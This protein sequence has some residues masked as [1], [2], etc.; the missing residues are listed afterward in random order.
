MRKE[1]KVNFNYKKFK[2]NVKRG[3]PVRVWMMIS[4]TH[5]GSTY[6]LLPPNF[7]WFDGKS[8]VQVPQSRGQV[9]MW[10][11][12]QDILN[13]VREYNPDTILNGSDIIDG[14]NAKTPGVHR[15]IT[16]LDG[17]LDAAKEVFEYLKSDSNDNLRKLESVSGSHYHG[18]KDM[19]V[20]KA[21]TD[22]WVAGGNPGCYHGS[23]ANLVVSGTKTKMAPYRGLDANGD[24]IE[25][26]EVL[27]NISHGASSAFIYRSMLLD[28]ES[29]YASAS[30]ADPLGGFPNYDL[31]L[32]GHW[33]SAVRIDINLRTLI[34]NPCLKMLEPY[35]GV[36]KLYPKFVPEIGCT[37]IFFYE[38]G[39]IEIKQLR[40]PNIPMS[41]ALRRA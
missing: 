31:I 23:V 34:I 33:H 17:Q 29:M 5:C 19:G 10:D 30:A 28:R 38:N 27:V 20:D 12:Y 39:D 16:Q 13:H 41:D 40:Y 36:M 22:W 4:D 7:S 24:P 37:F 1:T 26:D 15:C 3:E 21:L 11:Y 14:T 2:R 18:S 25:Y 6:G 9:K 35:P 32:H 8:E